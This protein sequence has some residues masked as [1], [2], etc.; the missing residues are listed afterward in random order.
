[1]AA[2]TPPTPEQDASSPAAE[3]TRAATGID[4][5]D[6]VLGGGLLPRRMY[7]IE[8]AAGSGKTTLALH[9]MLAGR[10]NSE[11][12]LWITTTETPD[13]LQAA[14][15]AHGWSL[16]GIDVHA[17]SMAEHMARPEQQQTLFR[18]SHVELDETMQAVLAALERV[19]PGRVV[20]DSLSILRDMADAPLAYR[21]QVLAL[22]NALIA[23]GCTAVVTDELQTPP[24]MHL[25]TVAHGVVRLLQEVTTYGHERRQVEI[26]KM[27]AMPFRGGRH[28]VV[29]ETGG[30][31]V[32]PRLL[33]ASP[34]AAARAD[35][36]STGIAPLDVLLGGG[37]DGG[38]AT[39]L[40]G[41]TG[42][43]K[44]SVTMQCATAALQRGQSV[45]VY[46][47]DERPPTW[48]QR[49]D[50]LGFPLRQPIAQGT[51]VLESIDPTEMSPGQFAHAVQ[52][53]VTHRAVHLVII[54]S[55]SG[56]VHAMP[57]EHFL[58]LHMHALLTWLSQH[59]ATTLL[60]LDQHGLVDASGTSPLDLSYLADTVLLF[61]YFEDHGTI[62]RALSVVKR[63]SGPHAHTIH[64]I[65]LGPHGLVIS[66]PLTQ[67]RGVFTGVPT[68][69]GDR[70]SG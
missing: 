45:A 18:P 15:H 46:L 53:A 1:M 52:Y 30:L 62:R 13:E 68:D 61:R 37:L 8:G 65:I 63:R 28:D 26:V 14:A 23:C 70:I 44:S 31:R 12:G 55:L 20:L 58:T 24:D 36:H 10:A 54:D 51:L 11:R 7:V 34:A 32:F 40:L 60:V 16:E 21:R 3:L 50:Q 66:E 38:A 22:K 5:L 39:L 6:A 41:A 69:A 25:R 4:G 17:L 2:E 43:G 47:F 67:F 48:F 29:I 42:T 19:Q 49:A 57:D 56:Y 33:P 59:G 64:E 35:V 9:F 27:R